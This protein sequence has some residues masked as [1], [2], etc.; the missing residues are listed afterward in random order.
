MLES[1]N[2]MSYCKELERLLKFFDGVMQN[3]YDRNAYREH[4]FVNT[5]II[6]SYYY[7]KILKEYKN[8][9]GMS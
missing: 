3:N 8:K 5:N 1:K 4:V 2:T 7:F 9:C 6:G